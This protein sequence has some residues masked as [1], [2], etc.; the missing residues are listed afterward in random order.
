MLEQDVNKRINLTWFYPK[1]SRYLDQIAD[2]N[3]YFHFL[4]EEA[5]EYEHENENVP[6]LLYIHIPFCETFCAYCA[7]FKERLSDYTYEERKTIV[8]G[9][10]KE[11]EMYAQTPFIKK[12]KIGYIQFGGGSPS[13]LEVD[14]HDLIFQCIYKHFDMTEN[15][16]ISFEGNVMSLKDPAK[17]KKLKDLGVTRLSFGLQTFNEKIRKAVAIGAKI[18]DIYDTVEAIN[19]VG[20]PSYA[21]DIIYNF[22]GENFEILENDL[23]KACK[24]LKPGFIQTYRF[25]QFSNTWLDEKINKGD[26]PDPPT[27]QKEMDM[28]RFIMK[29]L[30]ENGYTN[31]VLINFFGKEDQPCFTGI[32][33]S[34]GNNRFN[35]S[36][37]LGIGPGSMSY[38]GGHNYKTYPSIK[39]YISDIDANVYPGEAGHI[40]SLQE[41]KSRVMV[42]FPNFTRVKC[43][44]IP[45]VE[46][47]DTKINYLLEK[48]Y[49][50]RENDELR[51]TEQ[52]KLWAGNI[53]YLFYTDREIKRV[54]RTFYSSLTNCTNP[55][56]Q[57]RMNIVSK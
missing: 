14:L 45:T 44:D 10:V 27:P 35:G 17:L 1:I 29:K 18:K 51:L 38:L 30:K 37:M 24:E 22:P 34:I 19:K 11:M 12:K 57:D 43:R 48:G 42:F 47:Y 5:D 46:G 25:N 13:C 9:M 31:Q 6:L 41:R 32:E 54:Q 3:D 39:Q 16:G 53:S 56:N 8:R 4:E 21:L 15:N 50:K 52:G 7:C 36:Y 2:K 20:F 26:F 23:E 49:A 28:F 55:F 40:S 33:H